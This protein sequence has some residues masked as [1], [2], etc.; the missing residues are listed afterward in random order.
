MSERCPH[1]ENRAEWYPRH[2]SPPLGWVH[3]G[4]D[5][6][7]NSWA[8]CQRAEPA[9][10]EAPAP[11]HPFEVTIKIGGEDWEYVTRVMHE[12]AIHLEAHGSECT[13]CSG[14]AGG[15]HSVS[16]AKRDISKE[17]FRKELMEWFE[18]TR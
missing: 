16:V 13:M 11:Q 9:A 5:E 14:G 15:S 17:E 1:C 2:Y 6:C 10:P 8:P 7:E 18:T 4:R 3:A 12:L